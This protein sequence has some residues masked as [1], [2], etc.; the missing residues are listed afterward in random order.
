MVGYEVGENGTRHLQGYVEILVPTRLGALKKVYPKAHWEFSRGSSKEN[1]DYCTKDGRFETFGEWESVLSARGTKRKSGLSTELILHK[2]LSDEGEDI[3]NSGSYLSRKRALDERVVEIRE[4]RVRHEQFERYRDSLLYKW[5]L[6]VL[7]QL[8]CQGNRKIL[9]ITDIVG[10][11]GKSHLAKILFYMYG[12][13]LFDGVTRSCD[14]AWMISAKPVGF[15]FDVTRDDSSKFSYSTLEQVK[16]GYVMSGKYAGIKRL[17]SEVPVIVFANFDPDR[18]K[19]SSDRWQ[20]VT[21]QNA[22]C[23][24]ATEALPTP[25]RPPP[26][27]PTLQEEEEVLVKEEVPQVDDHQH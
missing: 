12:Y 13:D 24:Q 4:L 11:H 27:L 8:A 10:G 20:I 9:W 22:I 23:T 2:L 6:S 1:Y 25:Y 18:S 21:V 5:Q 17:F 14:I 19:L 26:A 16:N 15:V 3:K 7:Q